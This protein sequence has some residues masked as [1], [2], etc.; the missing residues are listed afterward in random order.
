MGRLKFEGSAQGDM[1]DRL[2]LSGTVDMITGSVTLEGKLSGLTL[3]E[4]MRRRIPREFRPA[5]QAMARCTV[6]PMARSTGNL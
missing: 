1:F 2:I 4:T 5:M 3:S 6:Q